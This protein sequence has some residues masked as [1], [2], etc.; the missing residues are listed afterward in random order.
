MHEYSI[1]QALLSRIEA[2]AARQ[3]ALTVHRVS[4]QVGESSGVEPTLLSTAYDVLRAGTCCAS[5]A[6]QIELVP[7]RWQ[8]PRCHAQV[9]QVLECETCG[10]PAQ[11][12]HGGELILSRLELEV[13]THV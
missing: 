7:T 6:L 10:E 13:P 5:A 11:L 8:C 12:L 2:E 1:A 9:T 3:G 4:I